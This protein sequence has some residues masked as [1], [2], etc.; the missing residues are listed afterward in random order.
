VPYPIGKVCSH[1]QGMVLDEARQPAKE[2]EEG[3]LFIAGRGVMQGYWGLAEQSARS[4]VADTDGRRWY[5]TGDIVGTDEDGNYLYRAGRDGMVRGGGY[6]VELG[7]IEAS[8]YRH[9][10]IKEAA[11]VALPDADGGIR[12]RA[13]LS[14]KEAQ[15]PSLIELKRFCSEN[16]PLY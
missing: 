12:I 7:E 13:F 2:G 15:R 3:E 4:F 8:L 6:R 9:P 5:G 11:A 14:S 16:L 10:S 1:L